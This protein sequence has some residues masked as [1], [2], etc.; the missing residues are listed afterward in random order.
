M[1][2]IHPGS[3]SQ[4]LFYPGVLYF[5]P[6]PSHRPTPRYPDPSKPWI[7]SFIWIYFL[8]E[9]IQFAEIANGGAKRGIGQLARFR[10]KTAVGSV[11]VC[12]RI[13]NTNCFLMAPLPKAEP[14]INTR[15]CCYGEDHVN[16]LIL[17][18][19]QL[20]SWHW[21]T[22]YQAIFLFSCFWLAENAIKGTRNGIC[23]Q[24]NLQSL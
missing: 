21:P 16:T 9:I 24:P 8:L 3:Y 17:S 13:S 1:Q 6:L 11:C 15:P 4:Y 14:L 19:I 23:K 22:I 5:L 2:D 10:D 20:H 18:F 12:V 7:S